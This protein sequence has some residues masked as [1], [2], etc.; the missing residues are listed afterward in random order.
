MH[1]FY[2]NFHDISCLR[3]FSAAVTKL[4]SQAQF[5]LPSGLYTASL[6]SELQLFKIENKQKWETETSEIECDLNW[7]ISDIY[8][9]Q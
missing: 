6:L 8:A 7:E 9:M 2:R 3:A 1:E 5:L 4:V